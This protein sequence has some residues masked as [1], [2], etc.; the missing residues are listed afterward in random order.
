MR[1]WPM[2]AERVVL[3]TNRYWQESDFPRFRQVLGK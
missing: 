3:D 1:Y 2:K